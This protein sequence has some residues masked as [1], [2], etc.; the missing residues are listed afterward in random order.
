MALVLEE[1]L[2]FV[3]YAKNVWLPARDVVRRAVESRFEV[4]RIFLFSFEYIRLSFNVKYFHK[5]DPSGEIIM[6]SQVVPW[7]EHLFQLEKE[8]NVSPSIKYTIF[9]DDSYRIQ[10]MPVAQGSFVCRMFLPE[11]WAGLKTDA[12]VQACGIEGAVFVHSV[13]FIGGHKTK[14]GALAM[15]RKALEIGKAVQSVK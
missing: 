5:V 3:Q 10:C 2:E 9:E 8:M 14:D 11:A 4:R 12:L 1:F 13:R 6:L 15:A 7:K